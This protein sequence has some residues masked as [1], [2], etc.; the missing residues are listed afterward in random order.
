MDL[1]LTVLVTATFPW[2]C[3]GFV[4][5]MSRFEDALPAAVRRAQLQP[6][7]PPITAIPIRPVALATV[8]VPAQ[9]SEVSL[10]GAVSLGG[11]TNR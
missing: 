8:R 9:R 4:L 1:L 2:L 3:L 7:P 6:D 10:S 5:W 11:S